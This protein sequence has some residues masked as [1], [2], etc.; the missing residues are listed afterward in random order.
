MADR[1]DFETNVAILR[2]LVRFAYEQGFHELGYDVVDE[3]LEQVRPAAETTRELAPSEAATFDKAFARSPRRVP[4]TT[5]EWSEIE[6]GSGVFNTCKAGEEWHV[7]EGLEPFPFCHWCGKRIVIVEPACA[8]CGA[9]WGEH[10]A[11]CSQIDPAD[12]Q[13]QVKAGDERGS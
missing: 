5:C 1:N 11:D 12:Y 4:E 2:D 3:W 9:A 8:E 6:D 7:P 10:R 13:S